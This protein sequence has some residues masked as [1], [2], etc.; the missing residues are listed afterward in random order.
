MH[1]NCQL[2]WHTN[3]TL[4]PSYPTLSYPISSSNP[5]GWMLAVREHQRNSGWNIC[6]LIAVID[7]SYFGII[8]IVLQCCTDGC[9]LTF[10]LTLRI[11]ANELLHSCYTIL[12]KCITISSSLDDLVLV[13]CHILSWSWSCSKAVIPISTM[14][15]HQKKRL[16]GWICSSFS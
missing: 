13:F 8:E 3:T 9:S 14:T 2:F 10:I 7:S 15:W 12:K 4:T 6:T 1:D 5:D 11:G 16:I